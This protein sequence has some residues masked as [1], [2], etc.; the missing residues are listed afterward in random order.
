MEFIELHSGAKIRCDLIDGRRDRP[1]L[2]FLHEGLGCIEMWRDFPRRLCGRLGWRGLVY[3]RSG[4]GKSSPEPDKRTASYLH[5]AAAELAQLISALI[6][7]QEYLLVGHSDGGSIALIHGAAGDPFLKGIV[8]EAAHVFVEEETIIG[9]EEAVK[10]YGQDGPRGLGKYHGERAVD[11]FRAWWETWLSGEF[12]SWN[13]ESLLPAVSCPVLAVQGKE[14]RYGTENQVQAIITRV[15]GPAEGYLMP[16]CG[17]CPHFE[18]PEQILD[19]MAGFL[20][21]VG[22]NSANERQ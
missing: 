4:Y 9:I 2:I 19:K 14:D 10:K 1:W 22:E 15:S 11:V 17:H 12:R 18:Q 3:D 21:L 13:I 16:V 5:A 6:P 20:S 8:T 7:A